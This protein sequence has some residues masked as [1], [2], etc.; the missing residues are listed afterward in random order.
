MLKEA[1]DLGFAESDPKNDVEWIDTA[2]KLAILMSIWFWKSI[3]LDNINIDW[4]NKLTEVEFKY[5]KL[6]DKKIKLLWVISNV[7]N[8]IWAYVSPVLLN[9]DSKMAK[10][11]WVLN[12]IE[13]IW[14]NATTF[15]SWPWAWWKATA[16]AVVS[17]IINIARFIENWQYKWDSRF[18]HESDKELINKNDIESKFYCRFY[19]WDEKWIL[20]K[21]TWIFANYDIN[22]DQV[23]QH[24]HTEEEKNNL[25]FVITLE[26]SKTSKVMEAINEIDKFDF[27]KQKTFVMRSLD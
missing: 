25:P 5:A 7:R 4:I 12:A 6:L 18:L 10:T 9:K 19:I 15:Y 23:I 20:S 14:E 24:N 8:K 11:D 1:Q 16:S 27:I 3:S 26:K 2:Y 13:I 22:I 17:D 21:I